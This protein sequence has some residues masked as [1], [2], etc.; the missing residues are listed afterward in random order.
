MA[1]RTLDDLLAPMEADVFLRDYYER[2]FL[3]CEG[4]P[5]KYGCL[6]PWTALNEILRHHQLPSPRLRVFKSGQPVPEGLYR[7]TRG[8]LPR[9]MPDRLQRQLD[10]GGTLIIDSVDRIYDPITTLV[11]DLEFRFRSGVQVNMYAAWRSERGFDLHWD[12][13]DVIVIQVAGRKD[14]TVYSHS[15]EWPMRHDIVKND[16]PPE[17]PIW[18]GTLSEGQ[19]LYIP[20][21][22]WHAAVPTNEPT[23]HLTVGL[24]QPQGIEFLQWYVNRLCGEVAVRQ[25]LPLLGDEEAQRAYLAQLRNALVEHWDDNILSEYL[26]DHAEQRR[27][28]PRFTLPAVGAAQSLNGDLT[29]CT[30]TWNSAFPPVV[31]EGAK[32]GTMELRSNGKNWIFSDVCRPVVQLLQEKRECSL[33]EIVRLASGALTPSMVGAFTTQMIEKGLVRVGT[34]HAGNGLNAAH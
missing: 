23:L 20:R 27:A 5:G 31:T 6:M 25:N 29:T 26:Q 34:S 2:A 19:M 22:W 12:K 3:Y 1:I 16:P 21:G 4:H 9:I 30:V 15:R 24:H 10:E 11:E 14:W 7:E 18:E 17:K 13:H 32:A 28:R 8:S 33:V